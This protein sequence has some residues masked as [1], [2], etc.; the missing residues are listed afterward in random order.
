MGNVGNRVSLV[1][2]VGFFKDCILENVWLNWIVVKGNKWG[3]E[4]RNLDES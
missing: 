2:M 3:G 4:E 1:Y